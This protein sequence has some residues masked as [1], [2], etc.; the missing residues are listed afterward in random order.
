MRALA[1]AETSVDL[2][3]RGA[4]RFRIEGAHQFADVL[5]LAAMCAVLG[6]ALGIAHGITQ[7]IG[8]L[9]FFS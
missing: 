8:Q 9:N 5:Q 1:A 7:R 4:D 2:V 3:E 6:K